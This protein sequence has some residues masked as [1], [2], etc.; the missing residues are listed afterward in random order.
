MPPSPQAPRGFRRLRAAGATLRWGYFLLD[1]K[2]TKE[3]PEGGRTP[4]GYPPL[5]S[6]TAPFSFRR[7]KPAVAQLPTTADR[8][9]R[10][11]ALVPAP[12][13]TRLHWQGTWVPAPVGAQTISLFVL[14]RRP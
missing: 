9:L 12:P 10:T 4:L 14:G 2:V 8:L 13:V 1:E 6:Y 11:Y 7:P 5:F 3:S